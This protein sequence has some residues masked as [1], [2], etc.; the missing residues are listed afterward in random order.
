NPDQPPQPKITPRQWQEPLTGQSASGVSRNADANTL[1]PCS[2]PKATIMYRL[3]R[4]QKVTVVSAAMSVRQFHLGSRTTAPQL[5]L[6][7]YPKHRYSLSFRSCFAGE[8]SAPICSS[9]RS[10]RSDSQADESACELLTAQG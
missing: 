2:A 8:G 1:S 10:L 5:R 3:S 4:Q 9:S 7:H 6:G